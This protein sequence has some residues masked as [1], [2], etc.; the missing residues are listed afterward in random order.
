MTEDKKK[1]GRFDYLKISILGFA[2]SGLA[3]SM[4]TIILPVRLI[5]LVPETQKNTYLLMTVFL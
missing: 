2:L 3:G 1:F 5:D 4:N